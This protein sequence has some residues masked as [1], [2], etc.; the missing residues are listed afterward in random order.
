MFYNSPTLSKLFGFRL[1]KLYDFTG[2]KIC[3]TMVQKFK[4]KNAH[5]NFRLC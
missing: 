3:S 4:K 1:K 5:A 2:I